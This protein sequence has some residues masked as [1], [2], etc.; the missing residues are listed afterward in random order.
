MVTS[1]QR[2]RHGIGLQQNELQ[3]IKRYPNG[4]PMRYPNPYSPEFPARFLNRYPWRYSKNTID[5]RKGRRSDRFLRESRLIDPNND[6]E[7]TYRRHLQNNIQNFASKK[8]QLTE[9]DYKKTEDPIDIT[10]VKLAKNRFTKDDP[11][12]DH[13]NQPKEEEQEESVGHEESVHEETVHEQSVHEESVHEQSVYESVQSGHEEGEEQKH[14]YEH[15]EE[16]AKVEEKP[17]KKPKKKP[18]PPSV[19]EEE[20]EQPI[21]PEPSDQK[22]PRPDKS[23]P[24]EG[25]PS[26]LDKSHPKVEGL[27]DPD[28][29]QTP[30]QPKSV[31]GSSWKA[32][33]SYFPKEVEKKAPW[34]FTFPGNSRGKPTDRKSSEQEKEGSKEPP[35][36][37][38][39]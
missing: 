12:E 19:L 38:W 13:K 32:P 36:N 23:E 26:P 6:F 37:D 39:N 10:N 1:Y 16:P 31:Y 3:P 17:N 8:K 18:S 7:M 30:E 2:S 34:A 11:S 14:E 9:A 24:E 28:A 15:G 4:L 27:A 33:S 20:D 35:N 29:P 22:A 21:P 25:R 5:H